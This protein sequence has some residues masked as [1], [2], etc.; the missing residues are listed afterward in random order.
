MFGRALRAAPRGAKG[1]PRRAAVGSAGQVALTGLDWDG[2]GTARRMLYWLTPPAMYPMTFLFKLFQRQQVGVADRYYTTFF[3]GNNG[4][5]VWGAG[6]GR[7]YY[8]AHPYPETAG[9]LRDG[10]GDG[11]WEIS[12]SANDFTVKDDG[13]SPAPHISMNAWYAQA[14]RATDSG[15]GVFEHKYW[16]ALPS[17]TTANTITQVPTGAAV[18]PTTP[19]IVMGQAPDNGSGLSWG[20]YPRWEEQ[21]AIIRGIQMH[22]SALT[23]AQLVALSAFDTDASVLTYCSSNGIAVPWYLNMNPTPT[24]VTDKSGNARHGSWAGAARPTLWTVPVDPS[25]TTTFSGGDE[26]PVSEAGRWARNQSNAWTNMRVVSG[27]MVGT[28]VGND[29]DDSY[30]I[31]Q[32]DFGADYEINTVVFRHASIS[33]ANHEV[34]L[35]FRFLDDADSVRGYEVLLN[36]DGTIQCFRWNDTFSLFTEITGVGFSNVGSVPSN[37]LLKGK[38]VGDIITI[39]YDGVQQGTFDISSIPGTKYTTGNPGLGAFCRPALDGSNSLHF[40]F[41]SATV[42]RL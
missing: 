15:G 12:A 19:A 21:N 41:Q 7:S 38:I 26:N 11:K 25:F 39:Y 2:T 16:L 17:T 5:F 34:E 32:G 40:G 18:V 31:A 29:Y 13:V 6:Y 33:A 10:T 3:W 9:G 14:F 4:A 28:Q 1:L 24:D 36:K 27:N 20:G 35:E 42:T 23:Q 22:T 8:G 37:A 30:A